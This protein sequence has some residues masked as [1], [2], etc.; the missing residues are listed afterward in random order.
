MMCKNDEVDIT[1]IVHESAFASTLKSLEDAG[2]TP[3]VRELFNNV[4]CFIT[5]QGSDRRFKKH[6]TDMCEGIGKMGGA[7]VYGTGS[8]RKCRHK[9]V[10]HCLIS[11]DGEALDE[12]LIVY[13]LSEAVVTREVLTEAG[14]R[15]KMDYIH[16]LQKSGEYAQYQMVVSKNLR[17]RMR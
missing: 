5:L 6:V 14:V 13:K 11:F 10:A 1:M 2:F 17:E 8:E 4:L 7:A 9:Y 3:V 12:F 16:D 15:L